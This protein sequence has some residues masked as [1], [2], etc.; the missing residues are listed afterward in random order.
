MK[1]LRIIKTTREQQQ[2]FLINCAL[3]GVSSMGDEFEPKLDNLSLL[4]NLVGKEALEKHYN[5]KYLEKGNKINEIL[6]KLTGITEKEKEIIEEA[7]K[8]YYKEE[9]NEVE[10]KINEFIR[11]VAEII[12]YK[13]DI[14]KRVLNSEDVNS[15]RF[16]K[17]MEALSGAFEYLFFIDELLIF[18]LENTDLKEMTIPSGYWI[19]VAKKE[20]KEMPYSVGEEQFPSAPEKEEEGDEDEDEDD[21]G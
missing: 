4:L 18:L 10:E 8:E 11:Y 9:Y 3:I 21:E 12:S 20:M 19:Y 14:K 2:R 1:E 5:D 16:L 15:E 6:S 17:Y 13:A 7:L